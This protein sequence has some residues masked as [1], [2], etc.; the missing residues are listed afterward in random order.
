MGIPTIWLIQTSGY[1]SR[2]MACFRVQN[3]FKSDERICMK[4]SGG[5]HLGMR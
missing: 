2:D 1:G 3:N 5:Q 4:F